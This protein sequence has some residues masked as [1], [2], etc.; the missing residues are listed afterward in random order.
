MAE[1]ANIKNY[2]KCFM[3]II[4]EET[5]NSKVGYAWINFSVHNISEALS[6][7]VCLQYVACLIAQGVYHPGEPGILR[8]LGKTEK[9]REIYKL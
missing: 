1:V 2:F 6:R 4:P 5:C 3:K 7:S 9:L 8:E